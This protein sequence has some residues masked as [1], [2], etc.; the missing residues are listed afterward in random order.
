M[1]IRSRGFLRLLWRSMMRRMLFLCL[2]VLPF[3]HTAFAQRPL[4]RFIIGNGNFLL[5]GKPVQLIS[6]EMHFA[7]IPQEYWRDRLKM[8]RAMGLNTIATYIFWNYHEPEKGKYNFTGNAD[9]A[10]FVK[11]AQEESLWVIVRPSPYACAEWE[12]GGY[13][14]WLLNEKNL[15]V[16]SKDPEF[17][18]L[19]RRYF[20]ELG[21]QL[22]PLQITRGGSVI[23]LQLENEYGSYGN[24]K[25][26]LTF[27]KNIIRESGFDVELYTCDGPSQMP[28][29]YLPGLLPAVNGLDNVA[30]VKELINKY[31]NNT[32]PYF[33]AEWYPAWFDSWGVDHHVVPAEEYVKT[34]DAVLASGISI[35]MYMVHGGTTRGFMNGANF[36]NGQPYSPQTSSYDYDAPIDEAGNATHKFMMFREIIQKHLPPC[37][38]LPPVPPKKHT[39][40]VP[41]FKLE[42]AADLL[43]NLPE[44]TVAERPLSFEDL[45][46]GF[47]YVLYR[48]LLR[49]PQ[50]GL[51]QIDHLRDYALV[52]VNEKR[53]AV[54]DRR[55]N[56]ESVPLDV[57]AG[58]VTLD[59]LVENLGRINYGPYLND[60]RKG[61]TERVT[62]NQQE[63]KGW[64]FYRFPFTDAGDRGFTHVGHRNG[65]VLRRGIFFLNDV[66][67]TYVDMS[68]WGKG[69]V[70][71]NGHNL[72]R[73]WYIGPQQ[74]LYVPA[75]W[76]KQG[77]NE[78][79]V[80]EML[81]ENQDELQ[82]L[83]APILDQLATPTVEITGWYD[84]TRR[85]SVL[86]MQTKGSGSAVYYTTDGSEP[87]MQSKRYDAE[88]AFAEPAT[89]A[90]RAFRKGIASDAIARV[91]IHP[92]LSTGE[93]ITLTYP[94]SSR[95]P[96]GGKG[97]L[98]DGI[99]G[100]RN[101][102]DGFWQGYE[103]TDIE[104]VVDLGQ[105]RPISDVAARF[106]QDTHAWIFYPTSV[107]CSISDDG[108][109]FVRVSTLKQAV[110]AK[111]EEASIKEFDHALKDAKARFVKVLARSV[112]V[113]PPW[114]PG[115]GGKAWTFCDEITIE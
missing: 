84:G 64:K 99:R 47:G 74:T 92:S 38:V 67:D 26:Y 20:K 72:G 106:L 75:P 103:G 108:V 76:L 101:Y 23:M 105:V 78:I 69:C 46:Q 29:G 4:H 5:D 39:I 3:F 86:R 9:V 22:A 89:I 55:L 27:N 90:A 41:R 82:T 62:F 61:I 80:F 71:V 43:S 50:K 52:F 15:K 54:L 12:F 6:G 18:E 21:K 60:N 98:V 17:L 97:A 81:Q 66:G 28:N 87:T 44:P 45:H 79:V 8:A 25:E 57:P 85:S 91:E 109:N 11:T 111:D 37:T 33:I 68:D 36:D 34:L 77:R 14:Y 1:G 35:N 48:T 30:Q 32:G 31:H 7:R 13:P 40:V 96:A 102:R 88:L 115:A 104:A 2:L 112:G 93:P 110:A 10:R 113:C 24:D 73:Y 100:S 19:S 83:E 49:G 94:F 59:I 107:E 42:G 63:V 16:R 65:P 56:Q 58:E 53:V 70:W 95:Y 51:V 114:H